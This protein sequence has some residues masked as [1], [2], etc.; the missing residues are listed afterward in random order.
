MRKFL[1]RRAVLGRAII[2]PT[3]VSLRERIYGKTLTELEGAREYG[4]AEDALVEELVERLAKVGYTVIDMRFVNIMIGTTKSDSRRRAYIVD[5]NGLE[6][7][8]PG[9]TPAQALEAVRA[10]RIV[11]AAYFDPNSPNSNFSQA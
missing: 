7:L 1:P 3:A 11:I 8:A 5:L 4:P 2:K 6:K 10:T 9:L